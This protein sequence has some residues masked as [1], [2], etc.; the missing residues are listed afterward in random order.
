[1]F[2][3]IKT[4][5]EDLKLR[6]SELKR[7]M[8]EVGNISNKE[9]KRVEKGEVI[10]LQQQLLHEKQQRRLLQRQVCA[11]Y[12]LLTVVLKLYIYI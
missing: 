1:M 5:K 6:K 4:Q 8:K 9:R 2:F 3:Q 7:L 12:C 10:N 11:W